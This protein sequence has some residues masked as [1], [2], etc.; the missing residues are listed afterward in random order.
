MVIK[1]L[2]SY[3]VLLTFTAVLAAPVFIPLILYIVFA[4]N[5]ESLKSP[6]D[7]V[8]KP[9]GYILIHPLRSLA[10]WGFSIMVTVVLTP[11]FLNPLQVLIQPVYIVILLIVIFGFWTI[12]NQNHKKLTSK[13]LADFLGLTLSPSIDKLS[14]GETVAAGKFK[15][16]SVEVSSNKDVQIF[17]PTK[18]M[19]KFIVAT[20]SFIP[21]D[22]RG[23][24]TN[25]SSVTLYPDKNKNSEEFLKNHQKAL[26]K[27]ARL[28]K[29]KEFQVYVYYGGL[30]VYIENKLSNE[31]IK[32]LL[33]LSRQFIN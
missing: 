14:D 33:S 9:L 2:F 22:K 20:A 6:L 28:A 10:I 8:T 21:K 24:K 32:E 3:L 23:N 30:R 19:P 16:K 4:Q 17:F 29:G 31:E 26:E 5:K 27:I 11:V 12:L 15:G 1:T 18:E 25:L 13:E 7:L